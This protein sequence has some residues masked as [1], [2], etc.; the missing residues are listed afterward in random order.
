MDRYLIRPIARIRSDYNEKFGIPRQAGLVSELEQAV[1]I[2]PEFRN[3]DAI[4][5]LQ[6]FSRIWLIWGFS[7]NAIDMT[8]DPVKWHPTVRPPRL[9][10][11]TRKGV[12]ASRSPYRPNSLGLSNV[13]LLRIMLGERVLYDA[14]DEEAGPDITAAAGYIGPWENCSAL[15]PPDNGAAAAYEYVP[16]PDRHSGETNEDLVLI[17]SGADMMDGTPVFDI[18]PYI[19]Y[20]DSHPGACRGYTGV[21]DEKLAVV[22]PDELLERIDENR[23][24]GLIRVLELDPRGAYEKK[25]GYNYGLSFA[26]WDIKFIVSGKTLT[27]TDIVSLV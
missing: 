25:D 13:R 16:D 22:F 2:E 9:K 24:A 20:S 7:S 1:V 26:Q 4:R 10:G 21:T 5:G 11:K 23:R 17:V 18:K 19:P 12:W 3:I 8:A 15:L 27:V 6:E 14:A